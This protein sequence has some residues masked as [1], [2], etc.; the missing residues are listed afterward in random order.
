MQQQQE[1]A[2]R[3]IE[4]KSYSKSPSPSTTRNPTLILLARTNSSNSKPHRAITATDGRVR[5][6]HTTSARR[7]LLRAHTLTGLG[8][9][10]QQHDDGGDDRDDAAGERPLVEVLVHLGVRVQPLQLLQEPLHLPSTSTSPPPPQ[11][12][13]PPP[14]LHAESERA[15]QTPSLLP[16]PISA[17]LAGEEWFDRRRR[18]AAGEERREDDYE[19][20]E[21]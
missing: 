10:Q 17:P 16:S 4:F 8:D 3:I 7:R 14:Q 11:P 1:H 2:H 15:S 18:V 20:E 12:P 19:E 21:M 6:Q 5:E 13:S 9:E